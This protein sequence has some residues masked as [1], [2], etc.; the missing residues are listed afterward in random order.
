MFAESQVPA[1][2]LMRIVALRPQQNLTSP[3]EAIAVAAPY[4]CPEI[5]DD[6]CG[7]D[8]IHFADN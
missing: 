7:R 1:S 2:V 8:V 4:F 6:L 3:L 5:L